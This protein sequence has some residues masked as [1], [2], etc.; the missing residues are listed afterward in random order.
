MTD[1]GFAEPPMELK[2]WLAEMVGEK[3]ASLEEL[4]SVEV[5]SSLEVFGRSTV[6]PSGEES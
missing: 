1:K 2:A 3:P 5:V 6:C 4:L